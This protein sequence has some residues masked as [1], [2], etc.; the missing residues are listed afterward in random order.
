M[1]QL[2]GLF[3]MNS[4][5]WNLNTK[6]NGSCLLLNKLWVYNFFLGFFFHSYDDIT[7]ICRLM[8]SKHKSKMIQ[9][10]RTTFN[11][12]NQTSE[13]FS[14][15]LPWLQCVCL[16]VL[17]FRGYKSHKIKKKKTQRK[18]VDV[19]MNNK[20]RNDWIE[21]LINNIRINSLIY[22]YFFSFWAHHKCDTKH[23]MCAISFSSHLV[24]IFQCD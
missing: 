19:L 15:L 14:L 20:T 21:S 16:C 23:K 4:P 12:T 17:A 18:K 8:C 10:T 3:K 22:I 7:Q 2:R 24:S 5:K 13:N 11:L 1:R 9:F 6:K